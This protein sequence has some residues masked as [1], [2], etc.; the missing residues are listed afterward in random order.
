MD[1]KVNI[2]STPAFS[3]KF[4]ELIEEQREYICNISKIASDIERTYLDYLMVSGNPNNYG[5][6]EEL[7]QQWKDLEKEEKQL[8]KEQKSINQIIK[9]AKE[10]AN[11]IYNLNLKK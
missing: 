2:K 7:F 3:R 5:A 10:Y 11:N 6:A 1:Q 8:L 9:I 4:R